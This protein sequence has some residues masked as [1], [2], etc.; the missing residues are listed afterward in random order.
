MLG[1]YKN[2]EATRQI[3]DSDGWLHSGDMGIIDSE[4]NI[5]IKGRCKNMILGANGKNIYPEELEAHFNNKF[6]IGE[7][8]VV[9]R[10]DEKLV[11]L[12]H[13]DSDVVES[14]KLSDEE[15]QNLYKQ[16]LKMINASVPSYMNISKFE[17]YPE[18]FVKTPKRSIKR[19]LYS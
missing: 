10:E 1:Y 17:I 19:Y 3:I 18:E 15:L 12:I 4:G 13:P 5:F 16:Y 9:Q 2:E 6:A 11:V 8:L 14:N 7:S